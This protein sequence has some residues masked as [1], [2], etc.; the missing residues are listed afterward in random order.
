LH[1][2]AADVGDREAVTR[3]AADI[4]DATGDT[5]SLAYVD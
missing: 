5:A 2:T 1:V 3:L 4:Q